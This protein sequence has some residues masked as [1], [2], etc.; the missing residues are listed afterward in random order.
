[1]RY[2]YNGGAGGG[3]ARRLS[4][5]MLVMKKDVTSVQRILRQVHESADI[6]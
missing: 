6:A 3:G 5:V 2:T 4:S 1:M